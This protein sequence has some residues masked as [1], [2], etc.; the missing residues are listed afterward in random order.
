MSRL[1][2]PSFPALKA[3]LNAALGRPTWMIGL[4]I[5]VGLIALRTYN[6]LLLPMF[7]DEGAHITRAQSVLANHTLLIN[8]SGT[9]KF[10]QPWLV[11]LVLPFTDN[12]LLAAR[13]LS[14]I[15]GLLA[16]IGCYL[17]ARYLYQREDV[18]LVA[19][20]LYTLAPYPLFHDRMALTDSLLSALAVWGLL[21]SLA[22]V[23]Q[24]RWWHILALGM[25]LGAAAA[26]KL[27]GFI[28]AAFPLLAAALWRSDLPRRRTWLAILA[29]WL[30]LTPWLLPAGLDF[31]QQYRYAASRSWADSEMAGGDYLALLSENLKLIA[32]TFWTYLTPPL[33]LLALAEAGLS[34]RRRDKSAWL[35]TLAVLVAPVFFFLTAGK[36]FYP[37]YLLPA[38]PF[39]LILAA[40]G[41]VALADWLW[42]HKAWPMRQFQGGLLLAGL[43]LVANLFAVRFDYLLLT[44]PP[45]TPWIP[46]DRGQYISG[47]G[48]G[49]GVIDAAAY[50]RQQ[51]DELGTILVL[52]TIYDGWAHVL[53]QPGIQLG[54]VDLGQVAPSSFLQRLRNSGAAVFVVLDR[55]AEDEY[56]ANFTDG[57]YASLSTLVGSF[58]RPGGRTRVDVYRIKLTP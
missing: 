23:R 58:P 17:L 55:P 8:T 39:L 36:A 52:Y 40:R 43:F 38:F 34:L 22:V 6:L 46:I 16:G 24:G 53:N 2:E 13:T 56:A 26:T 14:A 44:D 7:H 25:C 21:F 19:A 41:L 47:W 51:A 1:I 27:S 35:L 15:A 32:N 29:A 49:Y 11:A 12:P 50:L 57:R 10:L 30:L 4:G 48:A 20:A 31:A 28:F 33:L 5:W 37:R 9:G 3:R 45:G 42:T 54:R 18:A